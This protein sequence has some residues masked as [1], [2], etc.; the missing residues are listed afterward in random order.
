MTAVVGVMG[1]MGFGQGMVGFDSVFRIRT[2]SL[3]PDLRHNIR[4]CDDGR[5]R[6]AKRADEE[7]HPRAELGLSCSE[8]D[9]LDALE[10]PV[11]DSG[12]HGENK[13]G[14]DAQPETSDA[15]FLDDFACNAEERV[16]SLAVYHSLGRDACEPDCFSDLLPRRDDGDGDGEDL[17]KGT[18]DCSEEELCCCGEC[19]ER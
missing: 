1:C 11:C 2:T 16:V 12:V 6:F 5:E 10:D 9:A 14:L 19:W 18:S 4:V 8:N 17:G 3:D 13:S 15:F 7:G